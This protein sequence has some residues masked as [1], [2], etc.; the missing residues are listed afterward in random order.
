MW[1]LKYIQLPPSTEGIPKPDMM[2]T[3]GTSEHC[4]DPCTKQARSSNFSYWFMKTGFFLTKER[5]WG[6]VGW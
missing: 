5:G 1:F 6:G 3:M 2:V 4:S